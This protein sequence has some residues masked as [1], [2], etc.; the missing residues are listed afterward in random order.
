MKTTFHCSDLVPVFP[1]QGSCSSLLSADDVSYSITIAERFIVWLYQN[2]LS[3]YLMYNMSQCIFNLTL[4]KPSGWLYYKSWFQI[5]A[6]WWRKVYFIFLT[7]TKGQHTAEETPTL[8]KQIQQ[9]HF[10][11]PDAL[12]LVGNVHSFQ[13]NTIFQSFCVSDTSLSC[14]RFDPYSVLLVFWQLN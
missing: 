1:H 11:A 3:E 12:D 5:K 8:L 13:I 14:Q 4:V 9:T 7:N 10:I 2:L 6:M